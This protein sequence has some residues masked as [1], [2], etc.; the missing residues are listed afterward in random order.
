MQDLN[1]NDLRYILAVAR[2][3]AISV[4]AR[5][6]GVN[7]TTVS[8]RIARAEMVL[9]SKLFERHDSLLNPTERGRLVIEHAERVDLEVM[10]LKGAATGGDA[11]TVGQVRVTSIPLVINRMLVPTL[12]RLTDAHPNLRLQLV[13]EPRNFSLHRR[14]ADIALRFSR[15][16]KEQSIIARRL[17]R[18]DY[19]VYGSSRKGKGAQPWIT[20]DDS[21]SSLPHVTWI[22]RQ[23]KRER[24]GSAALT[25]NDSE[26]ALN[27]IAA[28]AGRSLLPCIIGD[29][30]RQLT[31]L[32][33][34]DP[35]LRRDLWVLLHPEIKKLAR[36]RVVVEWLMQSFSTLLARQ[37]TRE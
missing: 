17:E 14:E 30:E 18:L 7:E 34:P 33:G 36:I 1:W 22:N 25:V 6:L 2:T 11:A 16:D 4:A 5:S 31:R 8:R 29:H 37:S 26:V 20:Y 3:G 9:G 21:M 27:A 28:G 35:V 12:D 32:S 24:S 13:A 23:I 15:P 10:R 19:A